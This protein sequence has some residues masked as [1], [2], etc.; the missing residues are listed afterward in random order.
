VTDG[1]YAAAVALLGNYMARSFVT[2]ADGHGGTL[3][4]SAGADGAAAAADTSPDVTVLTG[5][6]AGLGGAVER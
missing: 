4:A 2:T 5:L 1:R 6:S 3:I